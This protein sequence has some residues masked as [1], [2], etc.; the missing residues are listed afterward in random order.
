MCICLFVHLALHR[1]C[2]RNFWGHLFPLGSHLY[3]LVFVP[4]HLHS[5]T[6]TARFCF[7]QNIITKKPMEIHVVNQI[8]RETNQIFRRLTL[9]FKR[10]GLVRG[11]KRFLKVSFAK[12][13]QGC[14][15]STKNTV[16]IKIKINFIL[17]YY[18]LL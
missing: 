6:L 17:I 2:H 8:Y 3:S 9:P 16:K 4:K 14:I 11:C 12:C 5:F 18:I 7:L 10:F 1:F 13:S 15:Y